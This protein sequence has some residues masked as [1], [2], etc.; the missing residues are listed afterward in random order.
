MVDDEAGPAEELRS[1]VQLAVSAVE[2]LTDLVEEMHLNIARPPWPLTAAAKGRTSGFT[3][4]AYAMV[5]GTT[6]LVGKSLD[7]VLARTLPLVLGESA[8]RAQ[9]L[10]PGGKKREPSPEREAVRAVLNGVVG[11]QLARDGHPLAIRPRLRQQGV[12]L[13]LNRTDLAAAIAQPAPRV[14]LFIH[15]FCMSDLQWNRGGQEH[16]RSLAGQPGSTVLH[17][18]YNSGLRVHENGRALADLLE[19]L[20]REWPVE[21]TELNLIGYSM[22]GLVARSAVAQASD[23]GQ[24]WV[25]HLKKLIF[26]GTPHHGAPLARGGGWAHELLSLSRYSAPLQLLSSRQSLGLIDLR[27]GAILEENPSRA[28]AAPPAASSSRALSAQ[29]VRAPRPAVPLPGGVDCYVI[30]GTKSP[31]GADRPASDGLVPVESALGL[32]EDP[33]RGLQIDPARQTVIYQIGHLDLLARREVLEQLELW[34][35]PI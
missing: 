22:G 35:N 32:H 20:V 2:G 34:L 21:I 24:R 15:G 4:L 13:A 29:A 23:S 31:R 16:S 3:G 5:R 1:A 14:L 17:F 8:P 10:L 7:A 28:E 26:L 33:A 27:Q 19:E 30:A 12:S 6:R 25:T 18:H 9:L 11:D